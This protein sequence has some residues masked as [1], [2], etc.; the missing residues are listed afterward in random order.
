M[1]NIVKKKT[2]IQFSIK[3]IRSP[4]E[5]N[6]LKEKFKMFMNNNLQS[7]DFELFYKD[8]YNTNLYCSKRI[9]DKHNG[10]IYYDQEYNKGMRIIFEIPL[11]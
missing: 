11:M 4:I 3:N 7:S 8:K 1:I 10:K 5:P 6:E 2:Y 9:V